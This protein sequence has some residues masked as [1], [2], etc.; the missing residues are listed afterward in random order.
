MCE[1]ILVQVYIY[2][3]KTLTMEAPKPHPACT[4][5][6]YASNKLVWSSGCCKH[7]VVDIGWQHI[8]L[9]MSLRDQQTGCDYIM[10]IPST[11]AVFD[12][13]FLLSLFVVP[14]LLTTTV[15]S[16]CC[17]TAIFFK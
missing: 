9:K 2:I 14:N 1:V 16:C 11:S 4:C 6:V 13:Y 5:D 15:V 8:E 17:H 10:Q 3:P 12:Q 7:K